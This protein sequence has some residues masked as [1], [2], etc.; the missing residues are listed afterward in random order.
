LGEGYSFLMAVPVRSF[1]A[2]DK[3][4]QLAKRG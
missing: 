2:L 4:R 1:A 3:G